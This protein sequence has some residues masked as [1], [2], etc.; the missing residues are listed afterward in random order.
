MRD[1]E[2]RGMWFAIG[3]YVTWGIFPLYFRLL[4]PVP[5]IDILANRV[6]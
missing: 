3:C 1:D 4:A 6:I 5:A 2:R